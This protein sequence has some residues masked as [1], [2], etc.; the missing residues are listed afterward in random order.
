VTPA[1]SALQRRGLI[2]YSR[3]YVM[4]PDEGALQ[5]PRKRRLQLLC[6]RFANL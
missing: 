3:G 4:L 5:I 1:A 6:G 2:R